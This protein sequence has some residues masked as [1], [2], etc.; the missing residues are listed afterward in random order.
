MVKYG[1]EKG[2]AGGKD[3]VGIEDAFSWQILLDSF[4]FVKSLCS[5]GK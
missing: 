5:T 2:G 4:C 3:L 1:V